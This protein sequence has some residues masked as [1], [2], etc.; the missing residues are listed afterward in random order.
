MF[1]RRW[2]FP[3][4][5]DVGD[6]STV[7]LDSRDK[8]ITR[9]MPAVTCTASGDEQLLIGL[10]ARHYT[11]WSDGEPIDGFHLY[12]ADGTLHAWTGDALDPRRI[13]IRRAAVASFSAS[14][15]SNG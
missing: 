6:V 1:D 3:E 10:R 15:A 11:A 8:P 7:A 14:E 2:K 9:I 5:F 4:S 12:I 13:D